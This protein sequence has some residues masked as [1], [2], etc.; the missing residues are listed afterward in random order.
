[1]GGV[2][3]SPEPSPNMVVVRIPL[4]SR[5]LIRCNPD[6]P[7]EVAA[8]WA[9]HIHEWWRSGEPFLVLAGGDY[10]LMRVEEPK[11][12]PPSSRNWPAILRRLGI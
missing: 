10:T 11:P 8:R 7:L 2:V 1:M 5:W 3:V 9:D 12:K 4:G 6:V